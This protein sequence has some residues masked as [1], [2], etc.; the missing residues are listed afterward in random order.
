MVATLINANAAR[1]AVNERQRRLS[2][3]FRVGVEKSPRSRRG[4]GAIAR[5]IQTCGNQRGAVM[6]ITVYLAATALV[7][8]ILWAVL[9]LLMQEN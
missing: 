5:R 7:A 9:G 3:K 8:L 4:I 2:K 1:A 6:T